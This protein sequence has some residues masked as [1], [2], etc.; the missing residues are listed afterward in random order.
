MPI[1]APRTTLSPTKAAPSAVLYRSER[2]EASGSMTLAN[3]CRLTTGE[4]ENRLGF[5][6]G[7]GARL[8]PTFAD[9]AGEA[10]G[11]RAGPAPA[12]ESRAPCDHA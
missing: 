9:V 12:R 3:V 1:A 11:G 5:V 7:G 8:T 2:T 4:R 10:H 6:C